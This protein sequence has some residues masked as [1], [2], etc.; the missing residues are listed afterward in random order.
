MK[1]FSELIEGLRESVEMR[2]S[3]MNSIL[4]LPLRYRLKESDLDVFLMSSV[5]TVYATWEGFF[6]SVVHVLIKAVNHCN[7]G[8]R[9][10]NLSLATY[11]LDQYCAFENPKNGLENK[12]KH[13][14]TIFEKSSL[15]VE[16]KKSF[17]KSSNINLKETNK[18]LQIFCVRLIDDSYAHKLHKLLKFR[19]KIAHGEDVGAVKIEDLNDFVKLVNNLMDDV[20]HNVDDCLRER[21]FYNS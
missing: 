17:D 20:L 5:P 10:L 14:S 19:N 9:E 12:M 4:T 11:Y 7:A 21:R 16:I 18:F 8:V 1:Y 3:S 6:V 13:V 2:R 15:P